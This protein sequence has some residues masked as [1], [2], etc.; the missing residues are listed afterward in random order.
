MLR[1]QHSLCI[2]AFPLTLLQKCCGSLRFFIDYCCCQ[3]PLLF[4]LQHESP[5]S[6]RGHFLIPFAVPTRAIITSWS[7]LLEARALRFSVLIAFCKCAADACAPT[8]LR[9]DMA[10]SST[11]M[12]VCDSANA[13]ALVAQLMLGG[14]PQLRTSSTS[15][16][17]L[18]RTSSVSPCPPIATRAAKS[19]ASSS[20]SWGSSSESCSSAESSL[21]PSPSSSYERSH[22][23]SQV[24]SSL[25]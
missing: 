9:D 4:I 24:S 3:R 10:V 22:A 15:S 16:Y 6:L 21:F 14:S 7:S 13:S 19:A 8:S 12:G 2:L 17:P 11:P 20:S 5:L 1:L 25:F 23:G 18:L